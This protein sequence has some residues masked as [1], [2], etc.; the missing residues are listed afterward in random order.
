MKDPICG[1]EVSQPLRYASEWLGEAY[2]FCSAG[3]KSKFDS[4]PAKYAA[5][6]PVPMA[7][8]PDFRPLMIVFAAVLGL[9][10]V[11]Y[12][13]ARGAGLHDA[14][15]DFMGVFFIVFAG[16]KFLDLRGF[17]DA[18]QTYDLAAMKSRA[19]ALAYP[20]LELLLGLAYALRTEIVAVHGVTF[21]LMVLG[22]AGVFR[23]I[24]S[25]QKIRCACLGTKIKLPMT[26][27]T[28]LEDALMAVMAF[29]MILTS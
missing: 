25:G 1:M 27:V 13:L 2:G 9:T 29:I 14:M 17:A 3:C 15:S 23:A 18:Y 10:A 5:A 6:A 8:K 16:F 20:F 12:F 28:L 21:L 24:R 7:E 11:K 26:Y 22:S 19:Y 4:D